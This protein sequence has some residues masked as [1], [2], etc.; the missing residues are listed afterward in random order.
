MP[1]KSVA[2]RVSSQ[3]GSDGSSGGGVYLLAGDAL[4]L[5]SLTLEVIGGSSLY[6]HFPSSVSIA[7]RF[8]MTVDG[9]GSIT[10]RSE[11]TSTTQ[12][13][14]SVSGGGDICFAASRLQTSVLNATLVQNG[15]IMMCSEH[16][17]SYAESLKID[18]AGMID[19]GAMNSI[20]TSVAITG[21]PADVTIGSAISLVYTAP[22]SSH[23]W[24]RGSR[25]MSVVASP[26]PGTAA[27]SVPLEKQSGSRTK[28]CPAVTVPSEPRAVSLIEKSAS[29]SASVTTTTT[30]T[31]ISTAPSSH[32]EKA[33]SPEAIQALEG[34]HSPDKIMKIL[35]PDAAGLVPTLPT[36]TGGG[37]GGPVLESA[38]PWS[39]PPPFHSP[40]P[41]DTE[42]PTPGPPTAVPSIAPSLSPV[43]LIPVSSPPPSQP[44][45]AVS[46]IKATPPAPT[47]VL[48]PSLTPSPPL[49]ESSSP[50]PVSTSEVTVPGSTATTVPTFTDIV[51]ILGV[52]F[53]AF[54]WLLHLALQ[55]CDQR[56]RRRYYQS[57]TS[58]GQQGSTP[59]NGDEDPPVLI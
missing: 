47:T 59:H 8:A 45:A 57:I 3:S 53:V 6:L 25:P 34:E 4:R 38:P 39:T 41:S 1:R 51:L 37:G 11:Y 54:S 48:A 7:S 9:S 2:F 55:C 22:P 33:L 50:T 44:P 43:A 20:H 21:G 35:F 31:T 28:R 30:T 24:Y 49:A 23:V 58:N 40:K 14:S 27:S 17:S 13:V 15:S 32:R 10:V 5:V 12:L 16:A 52:A 42:P 19:T 56:S 18:G 36:H 26:T 29:A 46:V